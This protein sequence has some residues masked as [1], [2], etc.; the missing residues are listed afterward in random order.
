MAEDRLGELDEK[1]VELMS[2]LEP[3]A[4]MRRVVREVPESLDIDVAWVGKPD[5]DDTLLIGDSVRARTDVLDGLAVPKGVG[6]GGQVMLTKRPMWVKNYITSPR[7]TH[8]FASQAQLEGLRAMIAVPIMHDDRV[9]GVLYGANRYE[10]DFGDRAAHVLGEIAGR[11]A[12]ATVVAERAKESAEVA[13]YEERRR[14]A[15]ELHDTVGAMLYAVSAG[16][17]TLGAEVTS[18]VSAPHIKDK[19]QAIEEQASEAAA[20]LRGS[21]RVLSNAPEKVALGVAVREDTRAF[22]ERTGTTTRMI[23][24]TELPPLLPSRVRVLSA[25]T[26]EALLNVEKHAHA[27]SVVVTLVAVEGGVAVTV[28]D[29]GV[30]LAP[31][32]SWDPGLGLAAISDR[33]ARLGGN[34]TVSSG[35]DGGVSVRAWVPR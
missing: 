2:M 21:L 30:G 8:D 35:D 28:V 25:A 17:R 33:L 7:I 13:V 20:M 5:S 14:V 3:E 23:T 10:T 31:R 9:L 26:R 24:V 16:I 18:L 1:Y 4:V 32:S 6:L 27:D 12:T 19:L 34:L 29:D 22:Q 11:A 15:L